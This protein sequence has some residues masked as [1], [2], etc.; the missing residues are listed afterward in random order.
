M[1][2]QLDEVTV[3]SESGDLW[4]DQTQA[5][6][7]MQKKFQLENELNRFLKADSEFADLKLMLS[8]AEEEADT[9]L[10]D[11]TENSIKKLHDYIKIYQLECFFSGEADNN[12]CYLEIHAGAGGTEAQDWAQMLLRMYSRWAEIHKYS[13]E[14]IEESMGKRFMSDN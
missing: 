5:K 13:A 8:L 10:I 6:E 4:L 14:I 12:S 11:E 9:Q 2:K 7:T 3:V 1:K